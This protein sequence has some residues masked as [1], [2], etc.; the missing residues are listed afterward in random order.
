[1]PRLALIAD[2]VGSR[3][4]ADRAA[5]QAR[6]GRILE[7]LNAR[8]AG[9]LS[10]Y[11]L[12]LGDEFQALFAR[13]DDVLRD[14][15]LIMAELY[16]VRVRFAFGLGDITTAINPKQALGMDGPAFYAARAAM[17]E[18]KQGEDWFRIE[19]LP[20]AQ[21]SLCNHSLQLLRQLIGKW[22]R[23]RFQILCGQLDGRTVK[24]MSESL[25]LSD[26]AIYKN[27][28]DGALAPIQGL[29]DDL[30]QHMNLRLLQSEQ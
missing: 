10:P 23:P 17:S 7:Q 11:T 26:K 19:G 4:T 8:N 1:M 30:V 2:V 6:L 14:A 18:L 21:Q 25:G 20:H 16:P 12:T 22:R 27:I 13:A 3:K 29:F 5:L 24:A 15:A 9:L 28:S